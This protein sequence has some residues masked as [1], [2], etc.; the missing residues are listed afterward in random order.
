MGAFTYL[1]GAKPRVAVLEAFSENPDDELSVPEIVR[2]TG[3][4]KRAAYMHVERLVEEG[5]LVKSRKEGK[6]DFYAFNKNDARAEAL[7][8]LE[9]VLILG[10]LERQ[11]RVDEGIAPEMPF[12]YIIRRR[13]RIRFQEKNVEEAIATATLTEVRPQTESFGFPAGS[14]ETTELSPTAAS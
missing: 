7:V 5:L 1:F 11:I 8:Y 9:G 13:P 12:P 4:S 6:T 10:S 3:V 2:M 14:D